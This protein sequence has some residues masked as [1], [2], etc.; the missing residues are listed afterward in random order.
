MST[1]E[2][3]LVRNTN[4]LKKWRILVTPTEACNSIN[5]LPRKLLNEVELIPTYGRI[6]NAKKLINLLDNKDAVV[7]DLERITTEVFKRC[8][9]LKVISRFGEGCDAIDL[10]SAKDFGIKVTRTRGVSSLAVARHTMSLIL[11]LTHHVVDNDRNLKKGLWIRKPNLSYEIITIGI[12][13]FG[14][15]GKAVADLAVSFGFKILVYTR[16]R[17]LAGYNYVNS[18]DELISLSDILSLHL[19][20]TSGTKRI[21]SRGVIKKLKGKYLVNTAR[22]RLVDE[23]VLL[24]SLSEEDGLAGYATDV[25]MYEPIS[26]I[27]TQLAKHPKVICTPHIAALDKVTNSKV[28]EHAVWNAVHCL[29]GEHD[30]VV[31]YVVE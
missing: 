29:K 2:G 5:S 12:L 14:K 7:L 10:K 11:A 9:N 19:P 24:K 20:F 25:F 30:K 18:L 22:G 31:S 27:S 3:L 15:I 26:D 13:G 16:K 6:N 4:I 8:S 21:I 23:K 17:S 28:T 1:A